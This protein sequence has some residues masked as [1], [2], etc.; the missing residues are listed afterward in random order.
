VVLKR[1]LPKDFGRTAF[2]ATPA[3]ALQ[4]WR[5]DITKVDPFLL[6]MVRELVRPGKIVWDIGANVGLF[7]FAAA[8]LGAEVVAVEP[9]LWLA[10]LMHR[11]AQLNKLPVTVVPAAVSDRAGLSKLYLLNSGRASNSLAG[12]GC[13]QTTLTVTL[14]WLLEQ[15]PPPHV[16]K[17]DVEGWE[18]PALRGATKV[19][20]AQP[21]IFC[22]VTDHHNPIAELLTAANYEFYAARASDRKALQRPSRDT[23]AIPRNRS[24]SA[25]PLRVTG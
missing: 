19:L 1:H 17:I 7:S 13:A 9:D 2:Y 11:S 24:A 21:V 20:Q 23:L 18:Y 10:E 8:S 6:S 4:Y 25:G 14:D 3:A 22:E 5:P 12:S 16:L 15:F